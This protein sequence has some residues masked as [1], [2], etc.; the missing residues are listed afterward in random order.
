MRHAHGYRKLNRT[1]SHR[2]ATLKNLSIAL[3]ER[4]KIETTLAKA[5]ELRSTIEKLVTKARIDDSNC[6]RLVFARLQN[7]NAVKKLVQEIAP[8]YKE[9]NGGYTRIVKLG[10]RRGDAAEMAYIEFVN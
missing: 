5:K 1:S 7:K 9:R 3:I 2:L 10:K 6:H 4:E 8:R